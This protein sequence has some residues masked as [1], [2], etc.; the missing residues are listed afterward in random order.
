HRP[1]RT[2]GRTLVHPRAD[3]RPPGERLQPAAPGQYRAAPH[4]GL[5]GV[6]MSRVSILAGLLPVLLL[7]GGCSSDSFSR[8]FSVYGDAPAD[9]P[10]GQ[11][12]RAVYHDPQVQNAL[13]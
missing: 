5:D 9:S 12:E 7:A 11:C 1:E 8:W 3:P 4:R 6:G 13:A 2:A 10:R